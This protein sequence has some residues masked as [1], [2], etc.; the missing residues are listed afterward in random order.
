MTTS[1]PLLVI[2]NVVK[3]VRDQAAGML[4]KA[5]KARTALR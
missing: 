2:I 3:A 5:I 1:S 4:A